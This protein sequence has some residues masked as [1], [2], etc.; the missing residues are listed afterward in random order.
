M[1]RKPGVGNPNAPVVLVGEAYG[2]V[3]EQL[4]RPF[5]GKSGE[6]L[7]NVLKAALKLPW[8]LTREE[9]RENVYI[10]NLINRRPSV[11]SN[12]ISP[13]WHGKDKQFTALGLAAR[14]GLIEEISTLGAKTIVPLG[15]VPT[16]AILDDRRSIFSLR[17]NVYQA[18]E[19]FVVPAV[20]P[21]AILRSGDYMERR[22]LAK[23]LEKAFALA[24]G[25]IK[26]IERNFEINPPFD[27]AIEFLRELR[28][29]EAFSF[30]IETPNNEVFCIGFADSLTHAVCISY[31]PLRWT[32]EQLKQLWAETKLTLEALQPRKITQNGHFD[33]FWL[34]YW[35][36][37]S[38]PLDTLDDTMVLHHIAQ[39][40]LK[41]SLAMLS[42]LYVV[43]PF[44]KGDGESSRLLGDM[45]AYMLYCAKDALYTFE[46]WHKLKGW[47]TN[48]IGRTYDMTMALLPDLDEMQM[49]GFAVDQ[50][51]YTLMR[52]A[53]RE[54]QKA[55]LETLKTEVQPWIDDVTKTCLAD[56]SELSTVV[57]SQEAILLAQ[58]E[59][60]KKKRE[61]AKKARAAA[62]KAAK[63]LSRPPEAVIALPSLA[64]EFPLLKAGSELKAARLALKKARDKLEKFQAD[65]VNVNSPWMHDLFYRFYR[66]PVFKDRKTHQP[67]LNDDALASFARG[68]AKR[69]PLE[70]AKIVRRM[71]GVEQEYSTFLSWA[72]CDDGRY[73]CEYNP[74]GTAFGRFSSNQL[75]FRFGTNGQN[76]PPR[77]RTIL[78]ADPPDE[79]FWHV[80]FTNDK[81][82]IEW[83]VV[84]HLTADPA[85][86]AA[87]QGDTHTKTAALM[88]GATE[89]F[90]QWEKKL[91]GKE[92]NAE[93][94]A[95]LRASSGRMDSFGQLAVLP[96]SMT[97]RQMGKKANHALNYGEGEMVYSLSNEISIPEARI[98]IA[99]YHAA[100]PG[101]KLW[102]AEIAFKLQSARAKG[103][104]PQL[105][106]CFG[107]VIPFHGDVKNPQY[108][109]SAFSS[110][111]QAT[112]VDSINPA[113]RFIRLEI[114]TVQLRAQTHDDLTWQAKINRHKPLMD[115]AK[116]LATEAKLI[117]EKMTPTME[118][119][120][121]QFTVG[122]DLKLGTN[123]GDAGD[124]NP[125]GMGE[126]KDFEPETIYKR[127]LELKPE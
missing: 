42:S 65:P 36:D 18:H 31:S 116:R 60:V 41:K 51:Q 21:A 27:R 3:E 25:S 47:R 101:V 75:F 50:K 34:K 94:L 55:I 57:A 106:N 1:I 119:N 85:M 121:I 96:T 52:E 82:Q 87:L 109:K 113:M 38:I 88:S 112:A 44:Y 54:Q 10:T 123:M 69:P 30:D 5:Q 73:R 102:H 97:L 14:Q 80:L 95:S 125:R 103:L 12:D 98:Q 66:M 68:T 74:R 37:I 76:M 86:L 7:D 46:I 84:A 63:S 108:L 45:N 35:N 114:P 20:H 56:V 4:D 67:T 61:A 83:V 110:I 40:D 58:N 126:L 49:N 62:K 79:D 64:A 19:R 105:T 127:L 124:E 2:E 92:T 26:P 72:T 33:S 90:I 70:A 16:A 107:R 9:V 91:L 122:N 89:E 22:I 104:V 53:N 99:R 29:K 32:R 115:E 24:N 11:N 93:R 118:Y 77:V 23:D 59:E 28:G 120:G 78:I 81:K 39:P 17:G 48:G 43:E 6:L 100:Y 13:Y 8:S 71:R 15:V 117:A 111:P